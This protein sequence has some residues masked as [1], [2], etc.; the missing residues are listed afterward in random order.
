[1][2]FNFN[3]GDEYLRLLMMSTT[4][5]GTYDDWINNPQFSEVLNVETNS[6]CIEMKRLFPTIDDK[7]AQSI[8][9]ATLM[10]MYLFFCSTMSA[11][12]SET[13]ELD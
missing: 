13:P 7:V 11:T 10:Y 12:N 8:A 9:L 5:R 1:M 6:T 2:T 3:S 4:L